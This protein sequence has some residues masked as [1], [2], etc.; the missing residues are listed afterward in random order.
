MGVIGQLSKQTY[1]T[2]VMNGSPGAIAVFAAGSSGV[3]GL[4]TLTVDM[5]QYEGAYF[6]GSLVHGGTGGAATFA[7][8]Q[9]TAALAAF[10]SAGQGSAFS[11]VVSAT[12]PAGSSATAD[13]GAIDVYRPRSASG[14]NQFLFAQWTLVSSCAV[15]GPTY[16]LQYGARNFGNSTQTN[17]TSV[18]VIPQTTV[19]STAAPFLTFGVSAFVS[20]SS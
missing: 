17:S 2:T 18:R 6:I 13:H 16:C 7:I 8:R 10:T 14:S 15:L 20:P 11:P 9:S 4:A 5:A 1:L 3:D 19:S 12:L